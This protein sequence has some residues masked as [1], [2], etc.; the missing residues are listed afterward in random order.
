[1]ENDGVMRE[2]VRIPTRNRRQTMDWGLVLASQGIEAV[3]EN[4]IAGGRGWA[5]VV[6][7]ADEA[8]AVRSIRLY[9]LE[10][11]YWHWRQPLAWRGVIMDWKILFWVMLVVSV[12]YLCNS[13]RPD[14]VVAG[15]MDNGAVR[16]G[17]WWRLFTAMWLHADMAHLALNVTLGTVLL[18]LTMG[19]YGAGVGLLGAFLAGAGG[20]LCG[21]WLY[22]VSHLGVGSSGMVLGGLGMLAAQTFTVNRGNPVARA[23]MYKGIFAGALLFVWFGLSPDKN[24]DVVAHVGGFGSGILLGAILAWTEGRWRGGRVDWGAG[25]VLGGLIC[26]TGWLAWR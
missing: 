2:P 11:R 17:E 8:A 13:S 12:F 15:R 20:N 23:R 14:M 4:D 26:L 19:R 1:M 16:A 6:A 5:L 18:G 25:L 22:P 3:I 24:V 21:L 9:R 7:A 10:N